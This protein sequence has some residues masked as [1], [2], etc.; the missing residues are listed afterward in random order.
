MVYSTRIGKLKLVGPLLHVKRQRKIRHNCSTTKGK[1]KRKIN[2]PM[3]IKK[4]QT[5]NEIFCT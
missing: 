5:F 1:R 2:Y 3:K 4:N